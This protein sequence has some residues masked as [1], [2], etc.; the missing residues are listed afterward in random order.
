MRREEGEVESLCAG[1]GE[2][3]RE[4]GKVRAGAGCKI[5]D[6]RYKIIKWEDG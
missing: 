2:V 5:Q 4:K 1:Q 6:T 3:R